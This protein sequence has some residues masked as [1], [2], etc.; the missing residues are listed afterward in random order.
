MRTVHMT[1]SLVDVMMMVTDEDGVDYKANA[2]D[3]N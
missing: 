1:L 2:A 3:V